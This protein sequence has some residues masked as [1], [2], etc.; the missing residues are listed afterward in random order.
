VNKLDLGV[1]LSKQ[2]EVIGSESSFPNPRRTINNLR[3]STYT[4]EDSVSDLVDNSIQADADKI[5]ILVDLHG[6]WLAILDNGHGMNDRTHRESMKLGSET[7]SY[8]STD[9][10]KFG[11]GMKAASL[12]M[13]K[14]LTVLTKS[15]ES[16]DIFAR[17][18]DVDHVNET[19]DWEVATQILD[20]TLIP[21]QF[22]KGLLE[23]PGTCVLWGKIDKAFSLSSDKTVP[24][25]VLFA[26]L[27][28]LEAHLGLVFHRFLDGSWNQKNMNL[29]INGI[30]VNAWDPFC[31]DS[32]VKTPTIEFPL[33]RVSLGLDRYVELRGFVLPRQEDFSSAASHS[34]AGGPKKWNDSQGFYVY[35]NGRLIRH[36]GWLRTRAADEHLKLA[37]IQFDFDGS[38]DEL[39]SINV[40]KS[41]IELPAELRTKISPYVS[42]V[43]KSADERYR[44]KKEKVL[45]PTPGGGGVSVKRTYKATDLARVITGIMGSSQA[46]LEELK[47]EVSKAYPDLADQIGWSANEG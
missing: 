11:T 1:A 30:P 12:S 40:A 8:S 43:T 44:K 5:E 2:N 45:P 35:R 39:F 27:N 16:D 32:E 46:E 9:L 47:L 7:R 21:H 41:V 14:S 18:L 23:R 37:R 33:E 15:S 24:N 29:S 6:E 10:G 31:L 36:G 13:A 20:P 25:S 38:L 17:R 34:K 4:F 22:T 26:R 19:N 28:E 3:G 42:S